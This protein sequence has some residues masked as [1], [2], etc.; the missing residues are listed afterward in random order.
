MCP[1]AQWQKLRLL[2]LIHSALTPG[3]YVFHSGIPEQVCCSHSY[4]SSQMCTWNFSLHHS[5]ANL[6]SMELLTECFF[7]LTKH[8]FCFS[9]LH[10]PC[11]FG[12]RSG[13]ISWKNSLLILFLS[14]TL[15]CD[16]CVIFFTSLEL[17]CRSSVFYIMY[18]VHQ[19]NSSCHCDCF[20]IF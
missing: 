8:I 14:Y 5:F 2:H 9:N 19:I 10:S 4:L 18:S 11:C 17:Q 1:F 15:L 7:T 3:I 20:I 13:I 12:L 16:R 6:S